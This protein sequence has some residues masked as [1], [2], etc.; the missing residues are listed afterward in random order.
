M[1]EGKRVMA[2]PE[3]PPSRE[4]IENRLRVLRAREEEDSGRGPEARGRPTGMAI[5]FRIGVELVAGVLV[6]VGIGWGLDSVFGTKPWLMV[7]FL[8]LGGAAGVM[9]V[10][11]LMKGLDATIGLGAAQRRQSE[12]SGNEPPG[13]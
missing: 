1:F 11:R 4:D 5:G 6:G 10:Y 7:L 13:D 8:L 9:N 12:R 2:D 3:K